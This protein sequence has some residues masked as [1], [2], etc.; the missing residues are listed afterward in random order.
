MDGRRLVPQRRLPPADDAVHLRA[1]GDAR[2]ERVVADDAL[3]RLRH[4]HGGGLGRGARP[5][6]RPG[7]GG[8][9]EEDH[10]ASRLRR[11]L[12]GPGRGQGAGEAAP[13]DPGDAR[14]QPLGPG[15]HLR[16]AGRVP[17]AGAEG[18]GQRHGLP[19][20]GSVAPRPGDTGR[21]HARRATLRQRHGPLVPPT[22]ARAIPGALPEGRRARHGRGA[23]HRV[24]DRHRPVAAV[25]GLAR[26]LRRRW[27]P[28]A[29]DAPLPEGRPEAGPRRAR[30]GGWRLRRVRVGP[31]Q[32]RALPQAPHPARLLRR[33]PHLAVLAGGRPARAVGADGR[34]DLR[35]RRRSPSRRR[36]AGG[37]WPTWWPPPAAP[38]P[39][40]W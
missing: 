33:Q 28:G 29:P 17:G 24:R 5:P 4:L 11:V 2:R 18:L 15:G 32:A 1:G 36:S 10:G 22:R 34:A 37:P 30:I 16:G 25:A 23:G 27:L 38:T 35:V 9:L 13:D 21:E 40:G 8:V 19:G 20:D 39:T 12:A 7:A 3:R 14:A 31:G 26:R 6:P